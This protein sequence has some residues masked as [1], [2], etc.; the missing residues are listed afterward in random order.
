MPAQVEVDILLQLNAR[1][2]HPRLQ[3]AN[4]HLMLVGV[5]QVEPAF[6]RGS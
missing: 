3:M 1:A 5:E 4:G 6:A 2:E